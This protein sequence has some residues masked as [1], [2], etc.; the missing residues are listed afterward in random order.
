MM[1]NKDTTAG[2][3]ADPT[4]DTVVA[5]RRQALA[6]LGLTAAVVYAT[7]TVTHI[8]GAALASSKAR[9]SGR[10]KFGGKQGKQGNHGNHSGGKGKG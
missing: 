1:A 10:G 4:A 9:P 7:P 3:S 6:R 8:D 5:S 2:T